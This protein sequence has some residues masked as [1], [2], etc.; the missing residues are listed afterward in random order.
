MTQPRPAYDLL[1]VIHR[2]RDAERGHPLRS[3]L[4]L[5]EAELARMTEDVDTLHDGW[6][7][8]TCPE[9]L[10]PYLGDLVGVTGLHPLPA[11]VASQRAFVANTIRY[12]RRKGTAAVLEQVARDVTG[13]PARVVEYFQVL[14]TY[15]HLD[16]VRPLAGGTTEVRDADKL[17]LLTTPF[18]T[19][20]HTVDV[21]HIDVRRGRHN[22]ANL[23]LHL[24]RLAAY[25]VTWSD[26]RAVDAA[27]GRW[28][29][30][31]AGRDLPLFHVPVTETEIT[32]LAEEINVPG[33]IRRRALHRELTLGTGPVFA[34][35]IRLDED[36]P[37]QRLVCCD[38]TDWRR[39]TGDTEAAVDPVLGRIT[40]PAGA[41]PARVR[42]DVAY[43]F[44]G[45][46]GA[47]PHQRGA[48]LATALASS[49]TPWPRRVDWQVGVSREDEPVP[50]QLVPTI[51]DALLL[52]NARTSVEP[53]ATG[54][55]AI[56]DSA[57]YPED[58]AVV[59]PPGNRLLIVAAGWPA[60]ED[61]DQP[62]APVRDPGML[63]PVGRRPHLVGTITVTGTAGVSAAQ[64]ELVLDGLSVEGG[65]GVAPGDLAS[66]VIAD[67]T[68]IAPPPDDAAA[69][70]HAAAGCGGDGGDPIEV[71]PGW[72][73]A[74]GNAHLTITLLRTV[75]AGVRSAD[76]PALELIETI[77][78]AAGASA[79]AGASV[80]VLG[81]A[82]A[83]RPADTAPVALAVPGAH[84]VIDACTVL[85]GTRAR[86]MVASNA[87][88]D[89]PVEVTDRQ[90]GYVR[91]SYLP[92]ASRAPRR[93]RCHPAGPDSRPVA[94]T[95]TSVDPAHP[96]FC[97]LGRDCPAELLTGADDEGELG[98]YHFLGQHRRLANLRSQLDRYLRFGLEAGVFFTT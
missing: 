4:E 23:G 69:P 51:G 81:A 48:T 36:P 95:F 13:W 54:V 27:A 67:T 75:C 70:D 78:Y 71:E 66:L 85:G 56:L 47:G 30:D 88:L 40:L 98:A 46:I 5:V 6:F 91:F 37:L 20:A 60:R 63:V 11:G 2:I 82:G 10:V 3:L 9:W 77:A 72:V 31:P 39:P 93:Y 43:G 25:R 73:G 29:F 80:G 49:G 58:L 16:H 74:T 53:G 50:G 61:P 24:W 32:H 45:D 8:E 64:T 14:G 68:L 96:G 87:I 92:L 65:L 1:P 18:A 26:A 12:R 52:W 83:V 89:G 79:G 38:L 59:I 94:P 21:R 15:Q 19:Q 7:I 35:G 57:T 17:E 44:P 97:Q 55:I 62:G 22:I 84:A 28:T 90:F 41:A 86:S 42:V 33:P 76:L 34:P